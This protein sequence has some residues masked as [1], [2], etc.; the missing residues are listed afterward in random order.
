RDLAGAG[1]RLRDDAPPRHLADV[2][3]EVPDRDAA[4]DR[5]RAAVRLLLLDDHPED[6]RLARPVRADEA[7]L[8]PLEDAHRRLDKEDLLSVWLGARVEAD[9]GRGRNGGIASD[10]N[11]AMVWQTLA[12]GVSF[13]VS[14]GLQIAF[15][16]AVLTFVRR[17]RPAAV[18]PLVGSCV[19]NL[20]S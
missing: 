5:D 16:V 19:V 8:L 4:I 15:L 12:N 2:L 14:L 9:H 7:H 3:A 6:R 17:H 13:L 1:H 18:G 20:V 11:S 10:M